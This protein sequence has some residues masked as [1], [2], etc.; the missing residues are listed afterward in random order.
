MATDVV[1]QIDKQSKNITELLA[2][3]KQELDAD[4]ER[5]ASLQASAT[6]AGEALQEPQTGATLDLSKKKLSALPV[7]AIGLMKDKVER[8]VVNSS[9]RR[10]IW[11]TANVD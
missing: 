7:E 2:F 8:C 10:C 3:I 11:L 4:A 1:T 6:A 5:H 9:K